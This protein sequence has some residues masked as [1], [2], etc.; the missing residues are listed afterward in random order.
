MNKQKE[1][2]MKVLR[3]IKRYWA[4]VIVS[5]LLAACIVFSTLYI[6]IQCN[7]FIRIN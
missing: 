3:Y 4:Y 5:I 2:V 1:T 7:S 6:P